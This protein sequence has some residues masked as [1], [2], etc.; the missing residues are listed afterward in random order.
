[1]TTG[2]SSRR[3][4][5]SACP[6]QGYLPPPA[7]CATGSA[8][9]AAPLNRDPPWMH[10]RGAPPCGGAAW[11]GSGRSRRG[12]LQPANRTCHRRRV[13]LQ[14]PDEVDLPLRSAIPQLDHQQ[15]LAGIEADV[16]EQPTRERLV[17]PRDTEDRVA[18]RTEAGDRAL[19][20][21]ARRTR[22]LRHSSEV[23]EPERRPGPRRPGQWRP[24]PRRS[25]RHWSGSRRGSGGPARAARSGRPGFS[26]LTYAHIG[27]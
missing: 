17:Q 12:R 27:I 4:P 13:G 21:L 1:L 2:P 26:G 9:P 25:G 14:G 5:M 16:A 18:D 24:G 6:K 11:R 3:W 19:R 10:G 15:L 7:S 22:C 8:G 20:R 23:T